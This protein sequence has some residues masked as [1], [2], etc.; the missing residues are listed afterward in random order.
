MS[1]KYK[2]AIFARIR[3]TKGHEKLGGS[4]HN[5]KVRK[6]WGKRQTHIK[7]EEG[8]KKT[9]KNTK[10]SETQCDGGDVKLFSTLL[11]SPSKFENGSGKW[12]HKACVQAWYPMWGLGI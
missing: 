10:M 11:D 9:G 7:R 3:R 5:E 2:K 12:K 4:A 8:L 1:P 6:T